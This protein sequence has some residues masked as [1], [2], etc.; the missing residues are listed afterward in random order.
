MDRPFV[1]D[2]KGCRTDSH[3]RR[4]GH[5]ITPSD[6]HTHRV[7][8]SRGPYSFGELGCDPVSF[9]HSVDPTCEMGIQDWGSEKF[10]ST[11]RKVL[12]ILTPC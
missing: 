8:P 1:D 5:D 3:I 2:K 11:N 6:T 7:S 12:S 9:P 10:L 4:D